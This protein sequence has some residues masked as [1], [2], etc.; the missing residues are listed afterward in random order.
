MSR[1]F[2]QLLIGAVVLFVGLAVRHNASQPAID[3]AAPAPPRA[4][5]SGIS[6]FRQGGD[7]DYCRCLDRLE[8]AHALAG[9]APPGLPPLTD[10]TI[11]YAMSHPQQYPIINADTLRCVTPPASVPSLSAPLA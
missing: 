3:A 7:P 11:R 2:R 9:G 6:C 5:G 1:R 4:P 10:P 8:R